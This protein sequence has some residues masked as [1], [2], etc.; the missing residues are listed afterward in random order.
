MPRH[1]SSSH[2]ISDENVEKAI[3]GVSDD[4]GTYTNEVVNDALAAFQDRFED[5]DLAEILRECYEEGAKYELLEEGGTGLDWYIN[6]HDY[7]ILENLSPN[8]GV[9]MEQDFDD[10]TGIPGDQGLQNCMLKAHDLQARE[11]V[12]TRDLC[13]I[14]GQPALLGGSPVVIQKTYSWI[15]GESLPN[16][17]INFLLEVGLS[18]DEV[19]DYRMLKHS[20][21]TNVEKWAERR[22]KTVNQVEQNAERAAEKLEKHF[23]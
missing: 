6:T 22:G 2:P 19:L 21:H 8:I 4:Y 9:V 23:K 12:E 3:E 13:R 18:T 11:L 5:E 20:T 17:E 16:R 15:G 14:T 7:V 1:R 10:E